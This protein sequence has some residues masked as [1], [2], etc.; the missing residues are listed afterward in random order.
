MKKKLFLIILSIPLTILLII[1]LFAAIYYGSDFVG[2][3]QNDKK[4]TNYFIETGNIPEKEMIVV[5]NTHG[6][7]WGIEFYPSDFSKSVTTKTD[8]ENWK[9][10]VEEKGKLFNG[11]KLRDKKYLEDPKNCEFVYCASY[12]VTTTYLSYGFLVSGEVSFDKEFIQQHF[13][14]LPKDK[15]LYGFGVK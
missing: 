4:L 8:Y 10:W 2:R 14:Y 5:K 12:T 3:I 6:S 7:S 11:E 15:I 1:A 9:K 13:A